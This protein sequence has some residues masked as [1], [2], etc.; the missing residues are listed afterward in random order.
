[1]PDEWQRHCPLCQTLLTKPAPREEW[2]CHVCGW[3]NLPAATQSHHR[4]HG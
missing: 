3:P 2:I 1:M 4:G